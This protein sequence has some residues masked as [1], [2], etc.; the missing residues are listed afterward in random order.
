M[1]LTNGIY[2]EQFGE[3]RNS[4]LVFIHPAAV[5]SNIWREF[6][7]YHS[8]SF[9]VVIYD[10]RNHGLSDH[11]KKTDINTHVSD[12][13]FLIKELN[14]SNPILADSLWGI[15]CTNLF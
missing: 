3:K 12:L 11:K 13:N 9:F 2:F 4:P 1:K 15:N 5:D 6:A 7:I 8:K 14:L 10:L